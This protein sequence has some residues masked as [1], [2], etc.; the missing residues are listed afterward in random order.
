MRPQLICRGHVGLT[1]EFTGA[2][3]L[4]RAATGGMMGYAFASH[5][6]ISVLQGSGLAITVVQ[7]S[8]L[9]ITH[10]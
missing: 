4:H 5:F 9:A 2:A 3:W 7:G 6:A 8:G 1:S 10:F